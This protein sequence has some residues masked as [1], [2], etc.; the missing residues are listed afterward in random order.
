MHNTKK[1]I[2]ASK[3]Y[4]TALKKLLKTT[5]KIHIAIRLFINR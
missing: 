2:R 5:K 3:K 1:E 4:F